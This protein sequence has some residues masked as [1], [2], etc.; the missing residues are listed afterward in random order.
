MPNPLSET[1]RAASQS[2]KKKTP[3]VAPQARRR[4]RRP[5]RRMIAIRLPPSIIDRMSRAA[6]WKEWTVTDLIE[7]ALKTLLD[8]MEEKDGKPF[9]PIPTE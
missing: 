6:Y 2:N 5:L 1:R 4:S 9:G 3:E 7:E 8:A